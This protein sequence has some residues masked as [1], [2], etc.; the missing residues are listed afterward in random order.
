V[1]VIQEVM[2]RL[3]IDVAEFVE[4]QEHANIAPVAELLL[5]LPR[6]IGNMK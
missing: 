1:T 3:A 2:K 5:P 6:M 4:C